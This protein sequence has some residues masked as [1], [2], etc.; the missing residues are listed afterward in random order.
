MLNRVTLLFIIALLIPAVV[1]PQ[2][3][4]VLRADGKI[5]TVKANDEVRPVKNG[6]A[7]YNLPKAGPVV[8]TQPS[9]PNNLIDTLSYS[10]SSAANFGMFGQDWMLQWYEAPAD[11][12]VHKVAVAALAADTDFRN[13]EVKVVKGNWT[14]EEFKSAGETR[15]GYYPAAG[16][17]FTEITAFRNNPD[18]TGDWVAL[19]EGSTEPWGDDLW[20]EGGVGW[21]LTVEPDGANPTYQWVDLQPFGSPDVKKGEIFGIAV[22]HTGTNMDQTTGDRLGF[23]SYQP[24]SGFNG[25]KFYA[26]YRLGSAADPDN[27]WWS[28]AYVWDF[29]AEVELYGDKGPDINDFTV[30][31]SGV[32]VGPFTVEANITDENPGN[33]AQAGVAS[34]VLQYSVDDGATW[35]D[36]AMT[37]T[38]PTFTGQ[39]PAMDARQWVTYRVM[40][41]D[42]NGNSSTSLQEPSFY[43]FAPTPDVDVLVIFNG[44]PATTGYPQSYYFGHRTYAPTAFWEDGQRKYFDHDRWAYGPITSVEMLNNYTHIFEIWSGAADYNDEV[45]RQW[46]EA[47]GSRNYYLSGEEY[48]GAQYGY[49]NQTFAAG[50]FEYDIL[51]VAQ[52]YNDVSYAASTGQGLPSL[53]TPVEGSVFGGALQTYLNSLEP[54]FDSLMYN[55]GYEIGADNWMDVFEVVEGTEVDANAETRGV[56]N[57]ASVLTKPAWAHRTLTAGNKIVFHS[58]DPIS[59]NTAETSDFAYYHWVGYSQYNPAYQALGWFAVDVLTD[60]KEVGGTPTTFALSQNY[61]NPFNPATVI[62]FSIPELSKITLKVYDVLGKEVA[63][64]LNEEKAAG[65]YEVKFDAS[66]LSS[67]V[68]FYS[69]SAGNT[70]M[71]KKM[72]LMK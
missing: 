59:L 63:T 5:Y 7:Q 60:V 25:W 29:A 72:M 38:E 37:G 54:A 1:L 50:D 46:L 11:L 67:G 66:R 3:K 62:N 53:I 58:F 68:Y 20:G 39:I 69:L 23:W 14:L 36:V 40:A 31:A 61:P 65:N 2:S 71:T 26:A 43:I 6:T 44:F 64:L 10:G 48:L 15:W 8:R 33:P 28:R 47:D 9:S 32:D 52:S 56:D 4:T 17:G 24:S 19:E 30:L 27:G 16:N 18:V 34:A 21:P 45:I 42:V 55:P 57:V 13:V 41:T 22:K 35:T 51:G 49:A 12:F 70:L